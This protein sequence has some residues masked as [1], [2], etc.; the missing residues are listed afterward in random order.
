MIKSTRQIWE[1]DSDA[2]LKEKWINLLWYIG[3]IKKYQE[4]ILNADEVT[5][6]CGCNSKF[7]FSDCTA[8]AVIKDILELLEE[9]K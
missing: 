6:V 1:F 2:D 8:R 4:K 5:C 9:K 3:E 7:T